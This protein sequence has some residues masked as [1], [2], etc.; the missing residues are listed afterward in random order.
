MLFHALVF[1][2]FNVGVMCSDALSEDSSY[3][4]DQ[5]LGDM[6]SQSSKENSSVSWVDRKSPTQ[7]SKPST[8]RVPVS[9]S[10]RSALED[11]KALLKQE[12][13][14][15]SKQLTII[16]K[17]SSIHAHELE[18]D[19]QHQHNSLNAMTDQLRIARDTA[20]D[21]GQEELAILEQEHKMEIARV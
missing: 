10:G 12:G 4:L 17:A 18:A 13:E 20:Y 21:R 1:G 8:Q 11:M 6:A 2:I 15:L 9:R 19:L 7:L 14:N 5:F 3:D 16:D